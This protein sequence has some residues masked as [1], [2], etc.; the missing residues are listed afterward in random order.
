MPALVRWLAEIFPA[1]H[2]IRVSRAIYL[3]GEGPLALLPELAL[4]GL[5]GV[6]LIAYALRS[7]EARG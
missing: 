3:R 5:F 7:I 4:L 1:T 2:Y 6:I